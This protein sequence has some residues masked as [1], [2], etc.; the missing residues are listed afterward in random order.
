MNGGGIYGGGS[1]NSI[2]EI[3]PESEMVTP[4]R[5]REEKL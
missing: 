4:K 3:F 2:I 5:W 1:A